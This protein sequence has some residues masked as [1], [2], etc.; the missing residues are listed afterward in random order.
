MSNPSRMHPYMIRLAGLVISIDESELFML[1]PQQSLKA[2]CS[3]SDFRSIKTKDEVYNVS[4]IYCGVE[5]TDQDFGIKGRNVV[6]H[7][8]NPENDSL[9]GLG[10]FYENDLNFSSCG[11]DL[12]QLTNDQQPSTKTWSC[13]SGCCFRLIRGKIRDLLKLLLRFQPPAMDL[14]RCC[15]L[16]LTL[17]C[18]E[19]LPR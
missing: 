8:S 6:L 1:I 5:F 3:C 9:P 11:A 15:H 13:F 2:M 4:S 16:P 7:N 19:E 12:E 14:N 10:I 18:E 17:I